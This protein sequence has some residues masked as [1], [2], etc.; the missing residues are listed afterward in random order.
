MAMHI[1]MQPP[2]LGEADRSL[3]DPLVKLVHRMLAKNRTERPSMAEVAR[4]LER[5]GATATGVMPAVPAPTSQP[6][7]S[8][9]ESAT[10]VSESVKPIPAHRDDGAGRSSWPS[11]SSWAWPERVRR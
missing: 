8:V 11:R 9:N 6:M 4:E 5:I 3:P 7:V 1:Y 2:P 10:V